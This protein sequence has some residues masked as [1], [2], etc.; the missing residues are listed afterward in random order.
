MMM[1]L[2]VAGLGGVEAADGFVALADAGA[3]WR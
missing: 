3:A 2:V 1:I